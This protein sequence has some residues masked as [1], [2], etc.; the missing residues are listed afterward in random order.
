MNSQTFFYL[1]WLLIGIGLLLLIGSLYISIQ[2]EHDI[3]S[4]QGQE[5]LVYLPGG[6]LLETKKSSKNAYSYHT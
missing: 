1:A 2:A 6:E 3:L 5:L 4:S